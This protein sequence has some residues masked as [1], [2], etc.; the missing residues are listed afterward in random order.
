METLFRYVAPPSSCGYLPDRQWSLEYELVGDATSREYQDRMQR[1]WRRFGSMMF[2]PRC[3]GCTACQSL[4]VDVARF[5]PN[6]SQRRAWKAN[7][8]DVEVRA[9]Q[10]SVTQTKLR[11][12][13][14]YHLHQAH[15]KGWPLHPAKDAAGY[16]HSFV[17]NPFPTHEWCYY[18]AGR[19]IAVGYVDVLPEGMSAI[20]FYFDPR[21]RRRSLGTFNVLMLL[22]ESRRRGLPYLYL[23]Y[24]VPDCSS[25][26]YKANF[27][28][29]QI[30]RPDGKWYD[31]KD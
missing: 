19:L 11:L 29:N 22:D 26:S 25:L 7:A 28:P 16:R 15:H 14:L 23:G 10:P 17:D 13:D 6:R 31:F 20:Y 3:P 30:L 24:Y 21:H 8:D 1:G 4:R 9:G 12:Y 27:A 18:L 2:R 5:R